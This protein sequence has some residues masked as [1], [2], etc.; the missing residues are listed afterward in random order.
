MKPLKNFITAA[1]YRYP[2]LFP[3]CALGL[4]SLI[5]YTNSLPN[6]FHFDDFVGIVRNPTIRDLRNI[7]SYFTDTSSW[8]LAH[9]RDWRPVLQITYALNYFLGGL[10]PLVFRFFNLLFHIGTA[11]LIYLIV[12]EMRKGSPLE[13]PRES[14]W[15]MNLP[16]LLPGALFAVHT[17]N[18]EAINYIWARSSLLAAFFYLL[19]FYF[20][21]RGPLGGKKE[22]NPL[23]HVGGLLSFALGVAT[24]AT[25]ITLPATLIL[26]EVL[27]LNPTWQSPLK[28]FRLEPWRLKKYIPAASIFLA[29]IL[30][31]VILL[32]GTYTSIMAPGRVTSISYLLTQFRA[33][34]Y[35]L[36]LFLW[37]DPLIV[38]FPGFGWSHSLWD[39]RVL[40]SLG[41]I[42]CIVGLAWRLRKSEPLITFFTFWFFMALLPEASFI[43]LRDAVTGYRPYLANV[44]L[45]IVVTFLSL[46]TGIWIWNKFKW[47]GEKSSLRFWPLYGVFFGLVLVALTAATI[48]RN[49]DWRDDVT[50]WSDV[51]RKDPTSPRAY[52]NLGLQLLQKG[53]YREAEW[54]FEKAVELAPRNSYA[55]T[56]RGYF[57][58]VLDRDDQALSDFN[59]AVKLG[60]RFPYNFFYRGELYRKIGEYDK[61]LNDYQSA[62]RL[63][64]KFTDAHFGMA[65]VHLQRK[66]LMEATE[67]CRKIIEIDRDDPRG[68]TCLGG[69][70]MEQERF[71]DALKVYQEG[72][73]RIPQDSELWYSSGVAYEKNDMYQE[74]ADAFEKASL[75]MRGTTEGGRAPLDQPAYVV[76]GGGG[77]TLPT[78]PPSSKLFAG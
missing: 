20:F 43:P 27:F 4:I 50:L 28:L 47:I 66:E 71:P 18:T 78:P 76:G 62:L 51:L 45:S 40:L 24:K 64:P 36:R 16:A 39:T 10:N 14:L 3:L 44:G 19:A 42:L 49:Q 6:S 8:S 9:G 7:P 35:Y 48:K 46:K 75:L 2:R 53:D 67:A 1:L 32:P 73:A 65:M 12:D 23:W 41:L 54:M 72:L 55:Y 34:V 31:R 56:L 60:P 17:A 21:L 33:W 74:A 61:A 5:A 68:Y 22:R 37:P 25:A 70:L 26:Y 58:F 38:D 30:L 77:P 63:R 29:Y 59:N 15:S 57:N 69:L 13:V 52:M 11:F